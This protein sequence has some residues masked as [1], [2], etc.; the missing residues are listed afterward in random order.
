MKKLVTA[1][2]LVLAT[3]VWAGNF[4]DDADAYKKGD[5]ER[6]CVSNF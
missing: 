1:L 2:F 4:E 6:P 5:F 3:A